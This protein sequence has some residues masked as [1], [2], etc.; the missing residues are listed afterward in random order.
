MLYKISLIK[1]YLM[2]HSLI[3]S[4]NIVQHIYNLQMGLV[5]LLNSFKHFTPL[6]NAL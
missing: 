5:N 3:F 4:E 1:L 6:F 2:Y